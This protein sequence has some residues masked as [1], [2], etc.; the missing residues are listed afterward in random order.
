MLDWNLPC[1]LVCPKYLLSLS[2][3]FLAWK[4]D[5]ELKDGNRGVDEVHD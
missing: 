2:V 4:V 3:M 1:M 5:P